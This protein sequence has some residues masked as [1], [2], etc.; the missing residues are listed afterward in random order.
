MNTSPKERLKQIYDL[1]LDTGL[2]YS[3][4]L[5]EIDFY[6]LLCKATANNHLYKIISCNLCMFNYK[7]ENEDSVLVIFSIPS[8]LNSDTQEMRHISERIMDVLKIIE[9]CFATVDYMK[10]QNVKE[11]KFTYMTII[12]K[13]KDD[14]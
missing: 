14:E 10:L 4:S 11:D 5:D 8:S 9:E 7:F 12:K 2:S 13:V 6:A 1:T 3:G